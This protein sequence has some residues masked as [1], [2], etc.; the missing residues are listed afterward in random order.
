MT[1][2]TATTPGSRSEIAAAAAITA[3]ARRA[4]DRIA[5]CWPLDRF[6]A[7]NPLWPR[8]GEPLPTVAAAVRASS[9]AELLMPRAW[10]EQAYREG[11]LRDEHLVAAID[12]TASA[13]SL[14][15]LRA[16]LRRPRPQTPTRARVVDLVDA[17]RDLD[18][19]PSWR[20][21]IAASVSQVCAAYFD[22]G[23]ASFAPV[24]GDGLYALWRRYAQTD[25]SPALLMR[26]PGIRARIAELPARASDVVVSL[27]PALGVPPPQHDE[28]LWGL[29]LDQHGWASWCA[30]RRWTARLEGRD[31]DTIAELLAIRVAWEWLLHREHAE[32]L[33]RRWPLAM[34]QWPDADAAA[35][36]AQRE[37]WVLQTAMEIAWREPLLRALPAGLRGR[38]PANPAVQAVFCIDVRSEVLRRA[39]ERVTPSVQT[40]GFAG[41]VGLPIA[42]RPP[43]S[44]S[45]RPQLPGLLAPRLQ[46]VD[47][48]LDAPA[49]GQRAQRLEA[50]AAWHAF[51]TDPTAMFGFVE[52]MGVA[53]AA[54]LLADALGWGATTAPERVGLPATADAQRVPRL[55]GEGLELER[56]WELALGML[57]GMSLTRD[58]A[59]VVLLV[60]H[61][62]TTRNNPH[63][64]GLDCGAC[65]GQ[66][67]EV[68]ARV[69]A[70]L[71][72]EPELRA[73]LADRG[74]VIPDTT[75]FVAALHDTT[76][77]AVTLFDRDAGTP[78]DRTVLES[79]RGWLAAA[80]VHTRRERAPRLG[81]DHLDDAALERALQRRASD[82]AQVRPEWGLADNAAF[83]VAPR[84]HC[85][86][87]DLAGRCFL[88]EYRQDEDP[89]HSVLE[90][91]MTAPMVVTHWINF[92]YYAATVDNLHYGSGNKLLHNV[93]GGHIGVFE[94][95][96]G[97]LRI[98]LPLQSLHDG[99][100]WIHT[101][102]RLSVFIEAPRAAIDAILDE[103]ATVRALV[104]H[105]WISVM[106]IDVEEQAIYARR[107]GGWQ[108]ESALAA[109]AGQDAARAGDDC[110]DRG[111]AA[112]ACE[113]DPPVCRGERI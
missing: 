58:F 76:T 80:S 88:H 109:A 93:V 72:N 43:G 44:S 101:P 27:L 56:R 18:H 94:G 11:R 41:V 54:R 71:L 103:H 40:L 106:Q 78:A 42:Y 25:R 74:V 50:E 87:L 68:N 7:V 30:Y 46:A 90:L 12:A 98:G 14:A 2:D 70:A 13:C 91:I 63:A 89:D 60:G 84:E 39:L 15:E 22:D 59:K 31:D 85:R 51:K 62:S 9:G 16:L 96:S 64:A 19:A 36:A 73:Q 3:A 108:R 57:R 111:R 53:H 97:D 107:G 55:S 4:C 86:H 99:T 67:G 61:G 75:R 52:A 33:Q 29:L 79:L 92:Q 83:V 66:T 23:Q 102:L 20:A 77:D 69:A 113:L 82:W 100:R 24:R 81:L 8:V 65:C 37:D 1:D 48:G 112:G 6:I 105:G 17:A 47:E 32:D 49:L 95:N 110:A 5:P 34:R 35:L 28:Y 104:E 21:H 10:Y 45:A 26:T 38:R